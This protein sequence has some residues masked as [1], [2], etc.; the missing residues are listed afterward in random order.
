MKPGCCHFLHPHLYSQLL[1]PE[2]LGTVCVEGPG[3]TLSTGLSKTDAGPAYMFA[4]CG[5]SAS[6]LL[7]DCK[8]SLGLVQ[9][10]ENYFLDL[11]IP[12]VCL[13]RTSLY[14]FP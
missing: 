14:I 9:L 13:V 6:L 8:S 1:F 11:L 10:L 7:F 5:C 2:D 4:F 12:T 3:K